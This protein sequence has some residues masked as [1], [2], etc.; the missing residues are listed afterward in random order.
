MSSINSTVGTHLCKVRD[1]PV[2]PFFAIFIHKNP[3]DF[4]KGDFGP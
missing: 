1:T 4:V 3:L 2:A